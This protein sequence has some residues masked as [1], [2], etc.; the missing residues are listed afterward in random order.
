MKHKDIIDSLR[1]IVKT[2]ELQPIMATVI[3]GSYDSVNKTIDVSPINGDADLLG[4]LVNANA[5]DGFLLVPKDNSVV[6]VV[7]TSVSTGFV[8]LVSEV[9]LILL[10][11]DVNGGLVKI[12]DLKTQYDS[13]VSGIKAAC[14][15]AFTA[16][17]GIDGGVGLTAFNASAS[18]ILPLN[19]TTLENTKVKHG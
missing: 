3:A 5:E 8:A 2:N 7:L 13:F 4:I 14:V 19:K 17:A 6:G 1:S 10:N 15:A 18:A 12:D 11:G 9:D 16:Q